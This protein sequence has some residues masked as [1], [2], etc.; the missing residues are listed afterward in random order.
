MKATKQS[1]KIDPRNKGLYHYEDYLIKKHKRELQL[2]MFER[3][4]SISAKNK[5]WRLY[6]KRITRENIIP[7]YTHPIYQFLMHML[8]NTLDKLR[9]FTS[10]TNIN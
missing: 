4:L 2:F 8:D 5:V 9:E 6:E 1:I 7:V 10:I 3:N